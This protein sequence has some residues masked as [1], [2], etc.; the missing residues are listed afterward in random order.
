MLPLFANSSS[1]PAEGTGDTD[2]VIDVLGVPSHTGN[3]TIGVL[4]PKVPLRE[5]EAH[6]LIT[7]VTTVFESYPLLEGHLFRSSEFPKV[8]YSEGSLLPPHLS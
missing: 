4:F 5:T 3:K 8:A 2:M 6:T 1:T 7:E